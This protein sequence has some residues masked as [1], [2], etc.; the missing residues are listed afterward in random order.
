MAKK[1]VDF[2]RKRISGKVARKRVRGC[3]G[4]AVLI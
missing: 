1:M 2:R 4:C 3:I